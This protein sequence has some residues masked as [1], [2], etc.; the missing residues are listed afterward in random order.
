MLRAP[1]DQIVKSIFVLRKL[2]VWDSL[3]FVLVF[4][5]AQCDDVVELFFRLY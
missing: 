4:V 1:A 2:S 5:E 3:S